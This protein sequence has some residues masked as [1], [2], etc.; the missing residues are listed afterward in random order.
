[1]E[2]NKIT[3]KE[4]VKKIISLRQIAEVNIVSSLYKKQDLFNSRYLPKGSCYGL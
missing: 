3:K 1:M 4:V 2:E